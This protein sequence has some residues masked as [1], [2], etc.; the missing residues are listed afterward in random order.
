LL[1][2]ATTFVIRALGEASIPTTSI[3]YTINGQTPSRQNAKAKAKTS[4]LD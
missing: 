2:N 3:V 4:P 1:S